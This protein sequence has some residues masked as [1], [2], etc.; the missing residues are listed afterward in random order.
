MSAQNQVTA[1]SEAFHLMGEGEANRLKLLLVCL[2][3]PKS[4][5]VLSK[6]LRLSLPLTRHHMGLLWAAK[7]LIAER[8]HIYYRI[9]DKHVH[10]TLDD[11]LKHFA[12]EK[13]S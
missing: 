3:G 1:L 2:D 5:S 13:E 7:F 6:E 8:R 10:C 12:E 4:V 9:F 11:M